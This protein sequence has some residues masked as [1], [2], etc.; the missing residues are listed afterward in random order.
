MDYNFLINGWDCFYKF[1][2]VV[3]IFGVVLDVGSY[4]FEVLVSLW[5]LD[6]EDFFVLIDVDFFYYYCYEFCI[7]DGFV[8]W[9]F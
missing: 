6:V 3:N 7:E 1:L 4:D 5:D 2:D 9:E 8:G